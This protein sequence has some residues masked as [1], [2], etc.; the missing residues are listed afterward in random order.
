MMLYHLFVHRN[1]LT[2]FIFIFDKV[3]HTPLLDK[4]NN[5]RLSSPY[6]KWFQS[7]LSTRS[8]F[9]HILE[10]FSSLFPVLSGVP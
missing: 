5:S 8:Y 3:P 9:I 10:N 2:L 6:I 1:T 4:L 7:Y